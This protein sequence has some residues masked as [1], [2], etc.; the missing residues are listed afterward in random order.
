MPALFIETIRMER[1][2]PCNIPFHI[3]RMRDTAN[4]QMFF[5]P[6]LPHLETLCP[7]YLLGNTVKCR[8]VY[9]SAIENITF[10]TY[11]VR[12]IHSLACASLPALFD[13]HLKFLKRHVLDELR[14]Q[15]GA[16]EVILTNQQ[17]YVT[18]TSYSNLLFRADDDVWDT[19]DAPLLKG[20]M[21]TSMLQEPSLYSELSH[22]FQ[23][24]RQR[25]IHINH[26]CQYKEVALVNAMMPPHKAIILP[27]SAIRL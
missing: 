27:I 20:T 25:P 21:L 7:S 9:R 1:G 17:G 3:Q 23:R 18:D 13:Y 2:V 8:I 24:I 22:P 19:P 11:Q 16:D 26:L 4:E 14:M 12:N 5:P 6:E 10:D 15:C